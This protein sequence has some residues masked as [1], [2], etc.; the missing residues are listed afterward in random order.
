MKTEVIIIEP[1]RCEGHFK[2]AVSP[3]DWAECADCRAT[4]FAGDAPC[5]PCGGTGWRYTGDQH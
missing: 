1:E 5:E 3:G 4:G 2:S